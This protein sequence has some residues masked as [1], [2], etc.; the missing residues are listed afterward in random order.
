MKPILLFSLA[1][2]SIGSLKSQTPFYIEDF[3]SG[4]ATWTLNV[5]TGTEGS[6][7]NFFIISDNEGGVTPPG[8]GVAGNGDKTLH[9]TSVFNPAGGASYDA[10]GLC[11]L[12]FCPETN[13]RAESPTINCSG[14]NGIT[15][16]F[17]FISVGQ[18]LT[19]NASV[20]YYDGTT[21]TV[22]S[23]S[24]KSTVCGNGQGQWTSTSLNLPASANNNPSVKIAFRWV[25]NDD[26]VGTDP[27]LA[28]NNIKLNSTV[29]PALAVSVLS[30]SNATC[31]GN[32]DGD[33]S[34]SISGGTPPYTIDWLPG[35]PNG[36]GTSSITGLVAGS[37]TCN[38]TDSNGGS[39]SVIAT[40]NQ[41]AQ[42]SS[43]QSV[44]LCFGQ[45][46][47]IGNNTYSNSGVYSDTLIA[48]NG[49]DSIVTT[50]LSI[51]NPINTSVSLAA[52]TLLAAQG[53]ANYQWVNCSNGGIL[54]NGAN[55]QFYTPTIS[56]GYAVII[57]LN[58]CLDTSV[59]VDVT[60]VGITEMDKENLKIFP[61][62][63]DD[64]I[65]ILFDEKAPLCIEV[66]NALG[67]CVRKVWV[68]ETE[69]SIKLNLKEEAEGIYFIRL[70]FKDGEV[71]GSSIVKRIK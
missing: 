69:K 66:S 41:S 1:L 9:I 45:S 67:E 29:A 8:C 57:S 48:T 16:S 47:S 18:G 21:W 10:G 4:G 6:D 40:V 22:I 61:N 62:P 5:V 58:G 46:Y 24:I 32:S 7:P 20:W 26:G 30:I 50:T 60:T 27:S 37:Y 31:F 42:I 53:G 3:Q 17:D 15:L 68:T 35:N 63:F 59:C 56:G 36:D 11:G 44:N 54:I 43:S 2:L 12:L 13:R 64:E 55:N 49:C 33:A 70:I 28:I 52:S 19:D 34:S 38:V 39:A 65:Q 51:G 14:Q 23:N 71:R 25:N